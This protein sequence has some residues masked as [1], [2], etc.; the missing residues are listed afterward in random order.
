MN[1]IKNHVMLVG[2]MGAPAQITNFDNGNKVAR[3][4]IA[5]N[6][7]KRTEEGSYITETEWHRLFAWGNMAQF[8]ER[9]GDTGK[10]IAIHGRLVQRTYMTKDGKP[11]TL[12]EVEARQII[13]FNGK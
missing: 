12:T 5:I 13:G 11:K 8:I 1:S 2:N 7:D 6:R 3:F 10:K 4:S 9:F